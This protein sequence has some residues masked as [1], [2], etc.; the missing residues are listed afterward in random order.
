[1][2]FKNANC[3]WK[4]QNII[5]VDNKIFHNFQKKNSI[6]IY[7]CLEKKEQNLLVYIDQNFTKNSNTFNNNLSWCDIMQ[8][9][10]MKICTHFID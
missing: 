4:Y 9:S 6:F 7:M 5:E 1:M 10:K 2:Y 3:I 8:C